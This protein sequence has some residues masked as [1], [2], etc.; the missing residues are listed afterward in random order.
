MP[1]LPQRTHKNKR[2]AKQ[3]K[4]TGDQ[5]FYQSK[6]WKH[7]RAMYL[8]QYPLCQVHEYLGLVVAG[9]VVD[10]IIGVR[11]DIGGHPSHFDN[12]C[13]MCD[14]CHNIKSGMEAH[15]P[16]IT[17]W[18]YASGKKVCTDKEKLI[19]YISNRIAL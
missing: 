15:S 17:A 11:K 5:L 4:P 2:P 13:T 18:H 14:D 8:A 10:H 9:R 12:L 7:T 6:A 16:Y 1:Y 19:D 3:R